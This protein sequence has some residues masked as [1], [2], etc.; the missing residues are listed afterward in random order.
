MKIKV[1]VTFD[2]PIEALQK[3][4]F[5]FQDEA[6]AQQIR[7]RIE[8]EARCAF[9]VLLDDIDEYQNIA[10]SDGTGIHTRGIFK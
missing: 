5:Y 10:G 7:D 1:S 8:S 4:K 2:L 3:A 6:P 9:E